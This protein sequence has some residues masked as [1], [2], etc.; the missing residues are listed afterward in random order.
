MVESLN[1]GGLPT[2]QVTK[3]GLKKQ[4][5]ITGPDFW[6][7]PSWITFKPA[8]SSGWLWKSP[9]YIVQISTDIMQLRFHRV[10]LSN[11]YSELECFEHIGVLRWLGLNGVMI[12]SCRSPPYFRRPLELWQEIKP[13]LVEIGKFDWSFPKE[14]NTA[15]FQRGT[16][17]AFTK[18]QP[19]LPDQNGLNVD[20]LCKFDNIGCEAIDFSSP[21]G[22]RKLEVACEA[23]ALGRPSWVYWVSKLA[24][25]IWWPHHGHVAWV[26]EHS[27]D[28]MMWMIVQHRLVD[29]LGVLAF[30]HPTKLLA[31]RVNSYMG[32]HRSDVEAVKI[33]NKTT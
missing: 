30:A 1:F 25:L 21:G 23:Y 28:E 11:G 33:L 5:T 20:I 18:I 16:E 2:T 22:E 31:G 7:R 26:Q 19:N 12:G 24:S 3:Y 29:L 17:S 13:N 27:K 15:A 8:N 6:G 14:E 9:D 32:G 4:V 10:A